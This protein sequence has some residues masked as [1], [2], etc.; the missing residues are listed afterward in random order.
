M[1][2]LVAIILMVVST[3]AYASCEDLTPYGFPRAIQDTTRLCRK[4]YTVEYLEKC[5]TPLVVTQHL[6]SSNFGGTVPRT[7]SFRADPG[8]VSKA[9]LKSYEGRKVAGY[10]IGHLAPAEDFRS[11]AQ[12]MRESFLLTNTVPQ[13]YSLNRGVWRELEERTRGLAVRQSDVYVITGTIYS[14]DVPKFNDVCVPAK[15]FKVIIDVRNNQSIGYLIP[16]SG[17]VVGH[18]LKEFIKPISVIEKEAGINLL[19]NLPRDKE[20][21]KTLIGPDLL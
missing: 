7:G 18:K 16:N 5:K 17:T 10:D 14:A 1:K 8:V 2:K 13:N 12:A 6:T 20:S 11:D 3:L 15:L 4:S 21:I 9:T 19:P